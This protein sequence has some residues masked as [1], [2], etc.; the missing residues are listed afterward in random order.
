MIMDGEEDLATMVIRMSWPMM[1]Q[2][3]ARA[4]AE[5]VE[6]TEYVRR[7]VVVYGRMDDFG[8]GEQS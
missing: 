7:A 2:L 4:S 8:K 6:V 3:R 5:G 1:Q